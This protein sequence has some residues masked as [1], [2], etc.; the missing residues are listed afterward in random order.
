MFI[1]LSFSSYGQ[2]GSGK[3]YTME[4]RHYESNEFTWETDPTAGII[5]RAVHHIFSE[6]D[7]AVFFNTPLP[8][9]FSYVYDLGTGRNR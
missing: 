4:G 6:I 9:I 5:P 8:S 3:T 1:S 7:Q 2:T